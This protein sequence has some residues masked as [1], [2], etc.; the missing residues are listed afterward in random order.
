MYALYSIDQIYVATRSFP[1]SPLLINEEGHSLASSSLHGTTH[2]YLPI[3]KHSLM[4][5]VNGLK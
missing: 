5:S 4:L 2:S 1:I 3:L